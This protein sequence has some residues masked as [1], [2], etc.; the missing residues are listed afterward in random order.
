MTNAPNMKNFKNLKQIKNINGIYSFG[1][2]LG[3]GSFGDVMIATRKGSNN[4]VAMKIVKKAS[5]NNNPM[6]P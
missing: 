4:Q 5:L 2:I 3:K 1:K 6:L